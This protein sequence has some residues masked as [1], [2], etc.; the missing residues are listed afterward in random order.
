MTAP[1]PASIPVLLHELLEVPDRL[2]GSPG[3]EHLARRL[4]F[5]GSRHLGV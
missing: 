3:H 1:F 5:E 4:T 2:P